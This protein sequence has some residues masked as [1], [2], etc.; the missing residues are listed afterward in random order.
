MPSS[1]RALLAL[2]L[3][4]FSLVGAAVYLQLA[5]HMLPCPYCVIQRYFF[6]AVGLCALAGALSSRPRLAAGAG[7]LFALAGLGVAGRHLYILAHPGTSCGIDP[8]ET[9]LNKIPS[10]E[11]LP[12]LFRADG[13]CEDA[14]DAILGLAI[15]E[16]SALWLA[17][18]GAALLWLAFRRPRRAPPA[19]ES[20]PPA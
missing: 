16:W 4:S 5:L 8:V 6:L 3:I 19:P 13:L 7:A 10:A 2:S 9:F 12:W 11:L 15:P 20:A 14:T 1:R 18:L 17:S